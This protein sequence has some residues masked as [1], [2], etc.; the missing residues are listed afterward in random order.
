MSIYL[1]HTTARATWG[2]IGAKGLVPGTLC[3]VRRPE[4]A[5]RTLRDI[6]CHGYFD[7]G[8]LGRL[9][10]PYD[11]LCPSKDA[12]IRSKQISSRL[13][14][15]NLPEG[16]FRRLR[17]NVYVVSPALNFVQMG[18]ILS[19]GQLVSYGLELCGD[20]ALAPNT[21]RGFVDRPAL[22][23]VDELHEMVVPGLHIKG[24]LTAR[25]ALRWV[26]AGS[27]SP[28]ETTC[29]VLLC[30]P[31]G[32]GGYE[33]PM[34]LLNN[35]VSL[36]RD[37][38]RIVGRSVIRPDFCWPESHT[39][40]EYDSDGTHLEEGQV[41]RD[42]DRKDAF[43]RDGWHVVTI[44]NAR[45]KYPERFDRLIREDLAPWLGA[46]VPDLTRDFLNARKALR[47]EVMGFDPYEPRVPRDRAR[48][49]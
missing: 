21:E 35:K 18:E 25:T 4:D 3:D 47:G 19:V 13:C 9:R 28:R 22:T 23:T 29:F 26:R 38:A 42:V 14:L 15:R 49:S 7:A 5:E 43:M 46:S 41:I 32:I 20:Y 8:F 45:L 11:L 48:T 27:R 24:S 44:T 33:F 10:K 6:K 37:A 39:L 34:P 30:L 12:R 40:A 16:S 1:S 2:L 17:D 36:S 31:S